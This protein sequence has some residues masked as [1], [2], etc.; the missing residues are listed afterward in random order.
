MSVIGKQDLKQKVEYWKDIGITK[1][2]TRNYGE[3]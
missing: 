2:L 1:K 3:F